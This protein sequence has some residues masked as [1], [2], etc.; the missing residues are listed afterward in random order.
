ME[1]SLWKRLR[2]CRKTDYWM[3][4]N[5]KMSVACSTIIPWTLDTCVTFCFVY[6]TRIWGRLPT[7]RRIITF[8]IQCVYTWKHGT[9]R[10]NFNT[11][12][13]RALVWFLPPLKRTLSFCDWEW[14]LSYVCCFHSSD[15]CGHGALF[16]TCIRSVSRQSHFSSRKYLGLH[17]SIK[18]YVYSECFETVAFFVKRVFRSARIYKDVASDWTEEQ[19]PS[20]ENS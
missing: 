17:I 7:S 15:A 3:N 4:D 9:S 5:S 19:S 1:S 18:N 14:L 8:I 6:D 16:I 10:R 13:T 11:T 12:S 20:R 2:T